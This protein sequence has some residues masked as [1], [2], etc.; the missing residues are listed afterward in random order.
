MIIFCIIGLY[1]YIIKMNFAC[2]LLLSLLRL[3]ENCSHMSLVCYFFPSVPS[4]A[5]LGVQRA[6][7]QR[8]LL[9]L[10]VF[11]FESWIYSVRYGL[12]EVI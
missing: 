7:C 11:G 4:R 3:L 1:N 10:L 2:F 12:V 5:T 8:P 6:R 9:L